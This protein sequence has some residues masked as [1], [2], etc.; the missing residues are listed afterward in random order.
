[1]NQRSRVRPAVIVSAIV[2][3]T[4][5]SRWLDVRGLSGVVKGDEA[6][7]IAEALSIAYDR[8]FDF[9]RVDLERFQR[10]NRQGPEGIFL[11]N[12][13]GV[14]TTSKL[15]YGKA[16]AY[17]LFA[18]PFVAIGGLG[19]LLAF[20]AV[21]LAGCLWCAIR[22]SQTRLGRVSGA[23]LGAAFIL[24]SVVPVYTALL[25]SD[26][27][28]VSLV[29]FAYF[30]WLYKRVAPAEQLGAFAGGW[31]DVVAAILLGI[32]AYSK[33]PNVFLVGPLVLERLI[34]RDLKKSIMFAT[35]S[36]AACL[37]LF[38]LTWYTSGEFNYQGA[39]P[40]N[41]RRTFAAHFPF[42]DDGT[43]FES[44]G[45]SSRT[46]DADTG[47]TFDRNTLALLPANLYFFFVGRD[48]GLVPYFFPGVVVL[49]LFL[50]RLRRAEIWQWTTLIVTAAA[51]L[52]WL[53]IT[54]YSWNGG[55]GPPGNRYF[56]SFYPVTLFLL[57]EVGGLL[58]GA[59]A[60]IVGAAFTGAM[61]LHPFDATLAQKTWR[62]VAR[63]PL[64]WLPIELTMID[65][66]PIRLDGQRSRIIFIRDPY[67]TVYFY[68]MDPNSYFA[69]EKGLWVAGG[70]T[71][72]IVIRTELEVT[73]LDIAL[74]TRVP[75]TASIDFAG[76][77]QTLS[78]QPGSE[79][80]ISMRP[81]KSFAIYKDN[82]RSYA[83]VFEITT[84]DGYV[85]KDREPSTDSRNLGVF[86]KPVFMYGQPPRTLGPSPQGGGGGD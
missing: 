23:V 4:V 22:F 82:N 42:D 83:Y 53:V 38:A 80:Q 65:D 71:A 77:R 39:Q 63:A 66:L 55:G 73:R 15:T 2:L 54:P 25:T 11:K 69:E 61:V 5:A 34:R 50:W 52:L 1:M 32:A 51:T 33:P 24:A 60:F 43:T 70:A 58:S 56:L 47:V 8:D 84:S 20:N 31:T 75:N 67:P 17:P 81:K 26:L 44:G 49:A 79:A 27:F 12:I 29:L 14:P 13:A 36:A 21:L 6:T 9:D 28:N 62:Y 86:L 76:S 19:G 64:R 45:G 35:V 68:Y 18:A 59:V 46:N 78:V 72:E 40:P 16:L 85:P 30:L 48:A 7:Y 41:D 57:P 10:V 37:G 3:A 74:S